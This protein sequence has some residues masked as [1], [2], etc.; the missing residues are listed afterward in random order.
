MEVIKQKIEEEITKKCV[1][2]YCGAELTVSMADL[3]HLY[4][5]KC[6]ICNRQNLWITENDKKIK[7]PSARVKESIKKRK[8]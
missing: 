6:P 7:Y 1:C 8:Q 3:D 2:S 5:Y 4:T